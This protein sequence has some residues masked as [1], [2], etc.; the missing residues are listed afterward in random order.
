MTTSFKRVG[1]LMFAGLLALAGCSGEAGD[2]GPRGPK[3]DQG[4]PGSDFVPTG[5]NGPG[6][7]IAV[8]GATVNA[9]QSVSVTYTV[10][11]DAGAAMAGITPRF[12]IARVDKRTDIQNGEVVLPYVVLTKSGSKSQPPADPPPDPL[13]V[14]VNPTTATPNASAPATTG[15]LVDNG[16]GSFTYT[17]AAGGMTSAPGTGSN[18]GK[19][20]YTVAPAVQVDPAST[21]TYTIWLQASRQEDSTDR[22]TI[23]PLNVE[24]SFVPAGGAP[25]R[26]E[27]ASTAGCNT[28]HNGF[29][30]Y[31]VENGFH[32]GGRIEAPFCGI[33][34]NIERSSGRDSSGIPAAD[35]GRF[36]HRVHFGEHLAIAANAFHSINEVTYPQ[37]FR[38][39]KACHE[40][41]AQGDQ[42]NRRPNRSACGSCHDYVDFVADGTAVGPLAT[43][44]NV[45]ADHSDGCRHSGGPQANDA[46]CTSCHGP[47]D[48]QGYHVP[49]VAKDPNNSLDGGTNIRTNA[50]EMA[51][52]GV[53]PPLASFLEYDVANVTTVDA[54]GG[55]RPAIK[56]QIKRD[57]VAVVFNTYAPGTVTEPITDFVGTAGF[58]F[59]WAIPA[60]GINAPADFNK[61]ASGSLRTLWN[62]GAVTGGTQTTGATYGGTVCSVGT[63]CTC[64]PAD[65]CLPATSPGTLTDDGD[66]YYTAVLTGTAIPTNAVM[67][68]GGVGYQYDYATAA[69]FANGIIKNQPLT[70]IDDSSSPAASAAFQALYPYNAGTGSGGLIVP[71]RNVSK[72][73][74]G[75][76]ARRA[77]VS[78]DKCNACHVF[79]GA[80]P[81]F[82]VGQRNDGPTCAFCHNPGRASSGWSANASTFIHA[83]HGTDKRTV[84]FNWHAACPTGSTYSATDNACKD[85]LSGALVTESSFAH[86]KFPGYLADCQTCHLPGTYDFSATGSAAAVPNLL[87]STTAAGTLSAAISTSP[88]VTTG[89]N[90]NT[91]ADAN[92]L[93]S[94]I[95]AACVSC[96]DSDAARGHMQG[97]GGSFYKSR[98]AAKEASGKF[99]PEGCLLCHGPGKEWSIT[100][101]HK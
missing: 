27:V 23:T 45:D 65:P 89:V 8:T 39:C 95:M 100:E 13:T 77:I 16:G 90:Y 71:A 38:N 74:T 37:D 6:L 92:L 68:T 62:G 26:R 75:F 40:G 11:D 33:C 70:Q 56:F 99:A 76:K 1:A 78:N 22:R 88:Y 10:K 34:H 66:G 73:A 94:P 25:E 53:V 91:S 79:L 43:R 48:I 97:Q 15:V 55:I 3:G 87:W 30:K 98:A 49:T 64:T 85:D 28:C 67:L 21:A 36:V 83:I 19:T 31:T 5:V 12:A 59:A 101:V 17:F 96:H 80:A 86:V 54:A 51:A 69:E 61:T 93:T 72:V 82:H 60:D 14:T 32:G 50:A 84:G 35:A 18:A 52:A 63:P 81:S 9:D 58:Y 57:G 2:A 42:W 41:A 46:G 29:R 4:D 47:T 7:K 44:C 24:Y 20:T